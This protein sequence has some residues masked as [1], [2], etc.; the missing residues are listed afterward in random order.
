MS[1]YG[2]KVETDTGHLIW[3]TEKGTTRSKRY[4]MRFDSQEGA[5]QYAQILS[6]ANNDMTILIVK[7]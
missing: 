7:L 1:G 6:R 3:L 4:A 5:T 2:L